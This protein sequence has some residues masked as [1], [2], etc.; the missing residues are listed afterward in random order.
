M[1]KS[2]VLKP[3]RG[4]V[5]G[6]PSWKVAQEKAIKA[7]ESERKSRISPASAKNEVDSLYAEKIADMQLFSESDIAELAAE[8][9][10]TLRLPINRGEYVRILHEGAENSPY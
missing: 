6:L 2:N 5:A 3:R 10:A 1:L 9:E 4:G 8:M 7:H